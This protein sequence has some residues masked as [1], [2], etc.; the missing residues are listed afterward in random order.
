MKTNQKPRNGFTLLEL[1]VVIAIIAAISALAATAI[2]R[3]K[4]SQEKKTA[5][6]RMMQ[7]QSDFSAQWKA[8]VDVAKKESIPEPVRVLAGNDNVRAR[9]LHIKF[10]LRQEFPQSFDE[11]RNGSFTAYGYPPKTAFINSISGATATPGGTEAESAALL[12]MTLAQSRGGVA[13]NAESLLGGGGTKNIDVGGRQFKVFIDPWG[14][15]IGFAR[16]TTSPYY[17]QQ[18][19]LFNTRS[20]GTAKDNEDP[21]G[22]LLQNW[23]S[24][25]TA[26]TLLHTFDG[27]NRSPFM[28]SA[29]PNSRF[30]D[31][32]DV[33]SYQLAD[34]G[35]K[36]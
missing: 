14:N 27:R 35:G 15:P 31:D 9:V 18:L 34:Q 36:N 21:E 19:Q 10:R 26:Q 32:D 1:L 16:W 3:M 6:Q 11:V 29:G 13:G 4:G 33:T 20:A 5:E 17:D 24:K 2:F 30:Y 23:A 7:L 22:K 25:A 8:V 12:M 28:Y